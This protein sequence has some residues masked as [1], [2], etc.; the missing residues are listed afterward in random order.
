MVLKLEQQLPD[1]LDDEIGKRLREIRSIPTWTK[2]KFE[3]FDEFQRTAKQEGYVLFAADARDYF[4]FRNGRSCLFDIPLNQRGALRKFAGKRIR[5]ICSGKS[6]QYSGR[7][8][9]A[10]LVAI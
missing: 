6:D 5:L 9:F 7:Y 8:F 3:L 2:R 1:D 4:L 10:N